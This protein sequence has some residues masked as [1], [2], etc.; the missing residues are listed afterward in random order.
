[1]MGLGRKTGI[2]LPNEDSG[3]IPSEEWKQ[4]VY[5]AKWY[6]GETI[7]VAIGQGYVSIT[8]IQAAW[9][10]GGLSTGGRLKQPHFVN[11]QELKKLG[12]PA[13]EVVEEDYP[14]S[15]STVDIVTTA[16]W[17]VVNERGTGYNAKI[18]GFD[19]AG[20]TGTAQVVGKQTN[21]KGQAYKD[22]AWFVGFAPYRNPEIVVA[23]FIENGGWGAE[24][25][26]PVVHDVLEAYY[27]KKTG[28]SDGGRLNTIAAK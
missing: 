2:D 17:G 8:P 15:Q 26:A 13:P 6:P 21:L 3:L 4:R 1:M 20:K 22:N 9:A 7:S 18:E 25:A 28:Q 19:V 11:P 24:A 14:I 5:K 23:A 27:K 10:M 12:R 16:M